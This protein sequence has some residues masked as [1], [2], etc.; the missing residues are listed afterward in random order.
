MLM[1]K[2]L[3]VQPDVRVTALRVTNRLMAGSLAGLG[4]YSGGGDPF[5][6]SSSTLGGLGGYG[7]GGDPFGGSGSTLG[8]LDGY[9][10]GGDP[11]TY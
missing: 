8:G 1:K 3:Y 6:G 4:D 5:G 2:K 11:F 7:G 9:G 10:G